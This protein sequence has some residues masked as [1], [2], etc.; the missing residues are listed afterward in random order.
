LTSNV[1][2]HQINVTEAQYN[3][4]WSADNLSPRSMRWKLYFSPA[5]LDG[6]HEISFV[7][8]FLR[9]ECIDH[10]IKLMEETRFPV[11]FGTIHQRWRGHIGRICAD[12]IKLS[13]NPESIDHVMNLS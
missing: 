4:E 6:K 9:D 1:Q 11:E 3:W 10:E 13:S 5:R 12:I 8:L 7:C 2:F